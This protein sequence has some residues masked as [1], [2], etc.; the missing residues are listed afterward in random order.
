MSS[1]KMIP[2]IGEMVYEL[3][4]RHGWWKQNH[5]KRVNKFPKRIIFYRAGISGE[6]VVVVLSMRIV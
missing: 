5:E 1:V 6:W 4:S 3:I 2:D